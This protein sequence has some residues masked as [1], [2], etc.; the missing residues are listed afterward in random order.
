LL[1]S[2]LGLPR[3]TGYRRAAAVLVA[4]AVV[5][6]L[7]A[8]PAEADDPVYVAWSSLLPGWSDTF[9]PSSDNDCTA[10]RPSCL[11]Q[12]L[13]ELAKIHDLN[14]QSCSHNAIFSLA[15]LRMTQFY[16]YT[17]DL[18]DYYQDVPF[19]NHQDAVFARYYTDAFWNWRNGNRSAVPQAWLYAFDAARNKTVTGNG[20]LLLGMSAHINRDLPFV[21]ASVGTVAP[22]GS[23]RKV[24]YDKVEEWLNQ[25]TAPML[26][27]AAQRYDPTLDDSGDPWG[28]SYTAL[29]QM[30]SLWRE[31]AWRNAEMLLAAPTP[32]AR[33]LVADK[34][35]ADANN[36][37]RGLLLTQAY[38]PPLS[39]TTS[40]DTYCATH[41]GDAS[42]VPYEFGLPASWGY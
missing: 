35:E 41:K 16:R 38:T 17:R 11:K 4:G 5:V 42:P 25:A 22:D 26:A 7:T 3:T 15:Y 10:G 32:A 28:L 20:D 14:G 36:V 12:T 8:V 27:E 13:K 9:T 24:D 21:I 34:I 23:S 40:R 1:R 19:A 30:V 18:P 39:S 33:Q 37:A 31:N 6:P 29:F 2:I